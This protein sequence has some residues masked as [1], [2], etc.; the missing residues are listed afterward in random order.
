M[1]TERNARDG[2]G[3]GEWLARVARIAV[4]LAAAAFLSAFGIVLYSYLSGR[5]VGPVWIGAAT[6]AW[7]PIPDGAVIAVQGDTCPRPWRTYLPAQGRFVLGAGVGGALNF[8]ANGVLTPVRKS[9]ETGGRAGVELTIGEIP[10]H[11][12]RF[13][14]GRS[15]SNWTGSHAQTVRNSAPLSIV[16]GMPDGEPSGGIAAPFAVKRGSGWR[17]YDVVDALESVGGVITSDRRYAAAKHDNMPPFV[18]LT[19]CIYSST[20]PDLMPAE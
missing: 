2:V 5:P 7:P 4:A 8:D 15:V 6:G 20:L 14:V 17:D 9:G 10:P 11:T 13:A 16:V 1:A 18:A 12:H 19:F 3:A